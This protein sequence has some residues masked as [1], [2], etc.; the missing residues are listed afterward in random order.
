MDPH[1]PLLQVAVPFATLGQIVPQAPQLETLVLVLT[2]L[3]PHLVKPAL[4]EN[5]HWPPEQVGV[6][7]GGAGQLVPQ[8]PQLAVSL[9]VFTH[10]PAQ[11]VWPVSQTSVQT[12]FEQTW[13]DTHPLLQLPQWLELDCRLTHE[14]PHFEKPALQAMP[15]CPLA[16]VALPFTGAV[17][18][19][20]QE[21]QLER[22][23]ARF[24]QLPAQLA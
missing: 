2:Q 11:L 12:P 5:P 6:A 10:W 16:Q 14:L 23:L 21:P 4:H 1:C 8:T 19:L 22:L 9:C 18:T 24:T 20:P 13:S 17:Q 7:F 3:E 15:H